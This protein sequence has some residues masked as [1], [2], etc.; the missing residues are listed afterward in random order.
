M[1]TGTG[2]WGNVDYLRGKLTQ[3]NSEKVDPQ[4]DDLANR[5]APRVYATTTTGKC[6]PSPITL[7]FCL[8]LHR[9]F[10]GLVDAINERRLSIFLAW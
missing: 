10:D 7:D 6:E 4:K 9:N 1:H 5:R 2:P 3:P 8:W